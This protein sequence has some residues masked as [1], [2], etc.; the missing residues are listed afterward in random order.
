M[1][2]YALDK[3][4]IRRKMRKH[5]AI[6]GMPGGLFKPGQLRK[7]KIWGCSRPRC[8]LCKRHKLYPS[9]HPSR[10]MLRAKVRMADQLKDVD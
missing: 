5:L 10:S 4:L 6:S 7:G 3:K 1:K 8:G 2:R 9:K